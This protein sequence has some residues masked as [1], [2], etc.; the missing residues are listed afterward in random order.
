MSPYLRAY[1]ALAFTWL[2]EDGHAIPEAVE[3]KLH[4]ISTRCLRRDVA[5][6]FYTRGMAST[7]RAVA[8]AALAKRGRV[9]VGDL[10]RY[11][12]HVEY[13][14]LFGKA[15]TSRPRSPYRAARRSHA[16]WSRTFCRSVRSGGKISFNEVLDDGYLRISATPLNSNARS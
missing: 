9:T 3:T 15:I 8:L 13:M 12:D 5:P 1:T 16:K 14:S 10:A 4:G 11:R 7:V 2:R 6:D